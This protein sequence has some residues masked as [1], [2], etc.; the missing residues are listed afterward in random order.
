MAKKKSSG[1]PAIVAL[2]AGVG[3]KVAKAK[4]ASVKA[5]RAKHTALRGGGSR[6]RA[7]AK[8]IKQSGLTK[9]PGASRR[10]RKKAY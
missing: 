4:P 3:K 7:A 6:K 1:R 5:G 9:G 8:T 2:T 10:W